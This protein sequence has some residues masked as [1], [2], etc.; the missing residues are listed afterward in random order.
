MTE[1]LTHEE[2][3]KRENLKTLMDTELFQQAL[4]DVRQQMGNEM[5]K[6][7]DS[8]TREK[9]H[10]EASLL[11]RLESRLT[12]YSNELLFLKKDEAA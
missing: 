5:L 8:A 3:R 4:Y 2:I 6:T 11:S 7:N 9:L 12:E 1:Q 10:L